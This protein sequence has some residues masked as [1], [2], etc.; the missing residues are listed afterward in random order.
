M[1]KISFGRQ[2]R[3]DMDSPKFTKG[4]A[5]DFRDAR[6][7][8]SIVLRH[9]NETVAKQSNVISWRLRGQAPQFG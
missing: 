4:R 8:Y 9:T 2:C 3:V 1:K 6:D 5:L 7:F